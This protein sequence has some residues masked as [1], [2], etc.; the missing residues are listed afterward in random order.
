ME[1]QEQLLESI[2]KLLSLGVSEDEIM[3]NLKSVGM[4]EFDGKILLRQAKGE[5]PD[6][7]K[8][9]VDRVVEEVT[10]RQAKELKKMEKEEE[11]NVEQEQK[12]RKAIKEI[13]EEKSLDTA[14]EDASLEDELWKKGILKSVDKKVLGVE[15]KVDVLELKLEGIVEEKLDSRLGRMRS[16]LEQQ[17]NSLSVEQE[18]KFNE[19]KAMTESGPAS[20][21]T[22]SPASKPKIE[23]E[24]KAL[25]KKRQE[26]ENELQGMM[27]K[28]RADSALLLKSTQKKVDEIDAKLSKALSREAKTPAG[29]PSAISTAADGEFKKQVS[30]KIAQLIELSQEGDKETIDALKKTSTEIQSLKNEMDSRIAEVETGAEKLKGSQESLNLLS[31]QIKNEMENH[32]SELKNFLAKEVTAL[33]DESKKEMN[34]F[35]EQKKQELSALQSGMIKEEDIERLKKQM[36]EMDLF[37]GQFIKV[38]EKNVDMM[39]KTREDIFA[40]MNARTKSI[41]EK[42]SE[43]DEKLRELEEFEK[44]FAEEMGFALEN[45]TKKTR[46][47]EKKTEKKTLAQTRKMGKALSRKLSKVKKKK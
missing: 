33:S 17:I 4:S 13:R 34:R 24:L 26:I 40:K 46:E 32:K 29:K 18:N 44:K 39:K 9:L 31:T 21:E 20:K 45:L 11:K 1:K 23:K 15:K 14:S 12:L 38:V 22:S 5:R 7:S 2:K 42:V 43:V 6:E 36:E 35:F 19:L 3:V 10:A 37:K 16:A 47:Q 41:D 28:F 27:I 8:S 30:E 25:E